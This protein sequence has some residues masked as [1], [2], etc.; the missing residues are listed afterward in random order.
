M[1]QMPI[2]ISL[3]LVRLIISPLFLPLLF[4][5]FLSYNFLPLNI[6]LGSIFVFFSFTDLFES[7]LARYYHQETELSKVLDPI[8]YKFLFYSTLIALLAIQRIHFYWVV[9]LIGREFF[10]M[11]LRYMAAVYGAPL[12]ESLYLERIRTVIQMIFL[13]F[14]IVNPYYQLSI[15]QAPIIKS[16]EYGL[17][18]IVLILT[19]STTKHYCVAFLRHHGYGSGVFVRR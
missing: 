12:Y 16:I 7:S 14:L 13:T 1:E 4:V 6:V 11:S 8:A 18:I 3:S 9:L 15:F 5:H 10:V 19:Y 17:L 2:P